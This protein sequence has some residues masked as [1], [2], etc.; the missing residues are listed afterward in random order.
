MRDSIE[1]LN[2]GELRPEEGMEWVTREYP[3]TPKEAE[4]Y[5]SVIIIAVALAAAAIILGN[6]I[7]ALLILVGAFAL[8]L[9][10]SREPDKITVTLSSEGVQI[11]DYFYPY[12]E[13]ESFNINK[14]EV[15]PRLFLKPLKTLAP[16][17][18]VEIEGV[19]EDEVGDYLYLFLEEEEE[20]QE[21]FPHKFLEYLG[22]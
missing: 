4:W 13:L 21:S 22:F 5:T 15:P 12:K 14:F 9:F 8:I 3:H 16:L 6:I 19:N 11:G 7:F 17:T 18:V 10:A 2:R 20:L 1:K